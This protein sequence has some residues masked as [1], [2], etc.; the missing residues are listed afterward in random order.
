MEN[1]LP[2]CVYCMT[3]PGVTDDHVPPKQFFPRPRPSDL[4]TVP[5]CLHCNQASGK[6]EEYFLATLM[7][8]QSG[9]TEVGKKLWSEKLRRM[10]EKNIGLKHKIASNIRYGNVSTPAGIYLG[11]AMTIGYDERRLDAVA[12]KIVRGLYFHER[13]VPL[14]ATT[15]LASLFLREPA[16]FNAVKQHNHMLNPGRVGW[17]GIFQYRRGF[18]PTNPFSSMWLLWFWQT[19]IFWIVTTTPGHIPTNTVNPLFQP[20]P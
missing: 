20:T 10:Y 7:F 1:Q 11:R 8:S 15:Q 2:I 16:H 4:L 18:V 6:D 19:H 17:K 9:I 13:G 3:N 5:A 12:K 14:N